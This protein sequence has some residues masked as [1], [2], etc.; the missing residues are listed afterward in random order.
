M[1]NY[2]KADRRTQWF[3][4]DYPG[5]P[6]RLN[7]DTMVGVIHTTETMSWPGYEGGRT[8]PNYTGQPPLKGISRGQWRAHF[9]DEMSSRALRNLSGGVETNTLNS[10]QFELI[11]TCDPKHAKSWNGQGKKFAGKDYVYWPK[12]TDNQLKWLASIMADMHLRHGMRFQAPRF[13][14]YPESYGPGGQRLSFA[15]W[16]KFTGMLGHQ[17]VPE[18]SHGDPG[19]LNIGKV[20]TF[21]KQL[22]TPVTAVRLRVLNWPMKVTIPEREAR[23]KLKGLLLRKKP[24]VAVFTEVDFTIGVP[25]DYWGLRTIS[26]RNDRTTVMLVSKRLKLIRHGYLLMDEWWVGPMG[27]K[28]KPRAYPYALVEKGGKQFW[29][30]AVHMPAGKKGSAA[31]IESD[32]ELTEF[33]KRNGRVIL[34]GDFNLLESL[35]GLPKLGVGIVRAEYKGVRADGLQDLGIPAGDHH[36]YAMGFKA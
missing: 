9:P 12:A 16:R 36:A 34:V 20:I 13:V 2:S 11:G 5:S 26:E 21:A 29:L 3:A 15:A 35:T 10:V 24:D 18:N 25:S 22:V 30:I 17:H 27:H 32:K 31:R 4:D 6:M 7:A 14:A 28:K 8:A 1:S 19:A 23:A 33:S